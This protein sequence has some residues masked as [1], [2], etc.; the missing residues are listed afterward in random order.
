MVIASLATTGTQCND[1]IQTA[2][3]TMTQWWGQPDKRDVLYSMFK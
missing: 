3:Q 2:T 1:A